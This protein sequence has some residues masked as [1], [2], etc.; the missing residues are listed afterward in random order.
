[1][2]Y[3]IESGGVKQSGG[4]YFLTSLFQ[5]TK[6]GELIELPVCLV[7]KKSELLQRGLPATTAAAAPIATVT[8]STTTAAASA[9]SAARTSSAT[10]TGST[11]ATAG[12]PSATTAAKAAATAGP[13]TSATPT[14]A[15]AFARRTSFVHDNIA[16]HEIMPVQS[17][18]STIGFF[19]VIN[20]Y[21]SKPAWLAG[22]TITDQSDV[23][24]GNSRLGE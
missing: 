14:G 8:V 16:A 15:A 1:V 19:V 21:E 23:G 12:P 3:K 13:P 10:A 9:A 6:N 22:K 7:F 24:S 17:L 18:N 20:F 4:Y 2:V 5:A 11:T